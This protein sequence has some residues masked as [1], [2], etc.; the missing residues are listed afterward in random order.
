[1]TGKEMLRLLQ[2]HGWVVVKVNGS[3]H[4]L[5]NGDVVLIVPIHGKQEIRP[6]LQHTLLREAGLK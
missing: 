6:G 3:H 5:R 1:M 2:A 4:H